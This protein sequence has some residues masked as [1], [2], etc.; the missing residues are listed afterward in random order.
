MADVLSVWLHSEWLHMN[1]RI[2]WLCRISRLCSAQ[3]FFV[4]RWRKVS[5][6]RLKSCSQPE[7]ETPWC[8]HPSCSTFLISDPNKLPW[9]NVHSSDVLLTLL[10]IFWT[11]MFIPGW[12]LICKAH[13]THTLQ[14][15]QAQSTCHWWFL[16]NCKSFF[17]LYCIM[18]KV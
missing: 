17:R 10:C 15:N 14:G 1:R 2:R 7:H 3:R 16:S 9:L 11:G 8:R 18:H 6:R 4:P 13:V 5:N 12:G